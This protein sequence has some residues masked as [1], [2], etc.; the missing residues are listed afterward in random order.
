MS[1]QL[2]D[3]ICHMTNREGLYIG[4]EEA[5]EEIKYRGERLNLTAFDKIRV[6]PMGS[7]D[8]LSKV[9]LRW[10]PVAIIIDSLAGMGFDNPGE[11]VE[12]C[13]RFKSYAIEIKSPFI[14]IDH[15]NKDGDFAGLNA[16]QHAV[17]TTMT[18]FNDEDDIRTLTTIKNRFGPAN[19]SARFYM[20]DSGL[21]LLE[22]EDEA[23][24]GKDD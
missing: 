14:V 7:D 1:L 20:T 15:V 12:V 21:H 9:I 19:V 8:D 24:S 18:F 13:K 4:T 10:R 22:E 17:D 3:S 6:L 2:V 16:L 11:A 5:V 23:D